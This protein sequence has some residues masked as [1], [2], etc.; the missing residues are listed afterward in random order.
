MNSH[1]APTLPNWLNRLITSKPT[2]TSQPRCECGRFC[3]Q[4][5]PDIT[6]KLVKDMSAAGLY[7][8]AKFRQNAIDSIAGL[9]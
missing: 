8:P 6:D 4:D 5:K 7:V 3:N 9:A 2:L 1:Y